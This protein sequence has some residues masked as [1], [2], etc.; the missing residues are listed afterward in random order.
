MPKA[1]EKK[2]IALILIAVAFAALMDGVDGSIVN[3]ALPA[4]ADGFGTDTGTVA[5]ITVSY[6]IMLAG[7]LLIFARIA[8]NGAI[9]KVFF[10]GM[11]IFTVASLLCGISDSFEML[12]IFR[13]VQGVGAAMMG[14]AAPMACV[15]YLPPRKLGMGLGILTLGCS[16]GFAIG[17]AI[18][19]LIKI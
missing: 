8:K 3:I 17:P 12:L 2:G 19:G 13:M 15:K 5:W 4:L 18:G 7:L 1:P 9:R 14:A 16:V 6:F 10:F 11:V